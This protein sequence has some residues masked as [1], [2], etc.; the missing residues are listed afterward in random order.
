MKSLFFTVLLSTSSFI[1]FSQV[2]S[3]TINFIELVSKSQMDK[4]LTG[5]FIYKGFNARIFENKDF[6]SAIG[7]VIEIT[8]KY[9]DQ[10]KSS[11]EYKA[12]YHNTLGYMTRGIFNTYKNIY[13]DYKVEKNKF[14]QETFCMELRNDLKLPYILTRPIDKTDVKEIK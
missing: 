13:K 4:T 2:D 9:S 8:W 1:S 14:C 7:K 11:I 10:K 3:A 6:K 5:A 12:I